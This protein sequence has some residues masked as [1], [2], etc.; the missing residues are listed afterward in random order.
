MSQSLPAI[1]RSLMRNRLQTSLTLVGMS[2]GVA[3]VVIVSGLGLGAHQKIE[4]QLQ[5]AGPT[6]IT[7][8]AG[9][10]TPAG[11]TGGEED[12]SGGEVGQG[13]GALSLGD[14]GTASDVNGNNPNVLAVRQAVRKTR[15]HSPPG[16]LTDGELRLLKG[17][18]TVTA[19][20]AAL[21]GNVSLAPD[22]GTLS[23]VVH[24]NG[25]QRDW[26]DMHDWKLTA[27]RWITASEH[28]AGASVALVTDTAASRLWPGAATPLGQTLKF[29]GRALLVTGIFKPP[30]EDA[31][32]IIPQVY[33]DLPAAISL[34][35]RADYDEITV[36]VGS[37]DAMSAL[38]KQITASL[39]RL[40]QLPDDTF[41]DFVVQTQSSAAMKSM[42]M[43][44]GT[45]RSVH[46]NMF[47]L[48][49]ASYEQM[50]RSLRKAG[51]TFSLLL[52][53]GA[54]VSLLVGGIGVM[55]IMLVAVTS[56]TREIGLRVAVGARTRDVLLQFLLE[57][58]VLAVLGGLL[59]IVLGAL[60]LTI[61][62]HTLHWATAISPLMLI[63][64]L[65]M[66]GATGVV[67]GYGPARRAAVL[68]PVTALRAE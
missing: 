52:A 43:S 3:M 14:G 60:G 50:A 38:A 8:R 30:Q 66:A 33:T 18:P 46:S 36:R 56:R 6:L 32:S 4:A 42:G 49:Q 41:D 59:G 20:A 57:A 22:A 24:V 51:R 40:R 2:V 48:E 11:A 45:V 61:A 34:L 9:N 53:G 54:A 7:V 47:N 31:G 29:N 67:F 23:H 19:V 15:F 64:A 55:N 10:F 68:D 63:L 21:D 13:G 65:L 37:V 16:P 28:D 1:V 5:S 44:P 58:V 39:R 12:A 17:L 25:F 35:G 27:G 62:R 26:P